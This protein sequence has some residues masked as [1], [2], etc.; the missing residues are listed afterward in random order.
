MIIW[1]IDPGLRGCVVSIKEIDNQ[2]KATHI[3]RMPTIDH[4]TSKI[5]KK[6]IDSVEL[7]S[8]LSKFPVPDHVVMELPDPIGSNSRVTLA[9]LFQSI[10]IIEGCCSAF[11]D[12]MHYVKPQVWKK[13]YNL[14]KKSKRESNNVANHLF[15]GLNVKLVKDSDI[16][17]ATL[18]GHYFI[19]YMK[20]Q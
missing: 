4:P 16:S 2:L 20:G 10:G 14:Y 11:C 5:V 13:A 3:Y 1:A 12:N 18:I 15:D 6:K 17:E 7:S 19:K 8:E 9:S